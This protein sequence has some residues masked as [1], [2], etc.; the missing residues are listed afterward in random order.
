MQKPFSFLSFIINIP[1]PDRY[2]GPINRIE[3]TKKVLWDILKEKSL[4]F[5]WNPFDE[6]A[7]PNPYSERHDG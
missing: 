2:R 1:R 6:Q 3:T 4:L 7:A 5:F